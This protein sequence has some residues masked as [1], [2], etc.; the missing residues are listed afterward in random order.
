MAQW[1]CWAAA[2]SFLICFAEL[3]GITYLEQGHA[4]TSQQ[5][6][7]ANSAVFF[8][9]AVGSPLWGWFS[10]YIRRR[11]LPIMV[12]SFISLIFIMII[13]Y[14]PHLS[15]N[16]LRICLFLF[17]F[18]S[19]VQILIFAIAYESTNIKLAGNTDCAH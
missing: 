19:S 2:L 15:L 17:G 3:W 10:D 8:G 11:V 5:A 9:W 1:F 4:L 6:A 18:A 16:T 14:V 13:L 7:N 12:G